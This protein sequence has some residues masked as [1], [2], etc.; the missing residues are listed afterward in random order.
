MKEE[1]VKELDNAIAKHAL[2]DNPFYQ[3]WNKGELPMDALKE[4]S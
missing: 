4:Y 1:F 2:L 3:M